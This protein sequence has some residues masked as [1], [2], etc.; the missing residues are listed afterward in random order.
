MFLITNY[1]G[2]NSKQ[3]GYN[4]FTFYNNFSKQKSGF[5]IAQNF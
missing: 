1:S 3:V 4:N 2:N 5:G